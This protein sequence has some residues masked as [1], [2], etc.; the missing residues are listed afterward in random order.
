VGCVD[1]ASRMRYTSNPKLAQ[2]E[3]RYPQ[4]AAVVAFSILYISIHF[5]PEAL[6]NTLFP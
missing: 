4:V 5:A 1:S 6:E 3:S 2:E